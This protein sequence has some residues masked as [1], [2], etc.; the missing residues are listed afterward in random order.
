MSTGFQHQQPQLNRAAVRSAPQA[1]HGAHMWR[2]ST[3][4]PCG[5]SFKVA[6]EEKSFGPPIKR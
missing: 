1:Q 4:Q 2:S 5:R 6:A 3:A